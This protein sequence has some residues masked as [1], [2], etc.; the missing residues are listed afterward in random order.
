MPLCFQSTNAV[1]IIFIITFPVNEFTCQW[2]GQWAKF[3]SN[4]PPHSVPAPDHWGW[5]W[6]SVLSS[7]WSGHRNPEGG[8]GWHFKHYPFVIHSDK[9]LMFRTSATISPGHSIIPITFL[10]TTCWLHTI[11]KWRLVLKNHLTPLQLLFWHSAPVLTP[12]TWLPL[13]PSVVLWSTS[14]SSL[15]SRS[16]MVWQSIA[17]DAITAITV[18]VLFP[19]P[20]QCEQKHVTQKNSCPLV[21]TK[22]TSSNALLVINNIIETAGTVHPMETKTIEDCT[23]LLYMVNTFFPAPNDRWKARLFLRPAKAKHKDIQTYYFAN[24]PFYHCLNNPANI[25]TLHKITSKSLTPSKPFIIH[26]D[27]K[28]I[29]VYNIVIFKAHSPSGFNWLL[30]SVPEFRPPPLVCLGFDVVCVDGGVDV[31][32]MLSIP[33]LADWCFFFLLV[34]SIHSLCKNRAHHTQ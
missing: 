13:P 22:Q 3:C 31:G 19:F 8:N 7:S 10:L 2:V 1:I 30:S 33:W 17:F 25:H 32:M 26:C 9:G 28:N 18:S 11:Q 20:C 29:Y 21:S 27:F 6:H 5:W 14:P 4:M 12:A 34:G 16:I 23:A 15:N 24:S